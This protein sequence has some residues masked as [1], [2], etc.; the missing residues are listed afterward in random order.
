MSS[1]TTLVNIDADTAIKVATFISQ[2][3]SDGAQAKAY[4]TECSSLID[5]AQTQPLIAKLLEQKDNILAMENES[6]TSL[7]FLN[8][9]EGMGE[10][11]YSV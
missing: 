5:S 1:H 10:G 11:E 3:I 7:V 8:V 4:L 6:G 9:A 2:Q